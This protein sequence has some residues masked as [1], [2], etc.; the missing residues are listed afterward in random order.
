MLNWMQST[1]GK[2]QGN[3]KIDTEGRKT[4][5]GSPIRQ[6]YF[7]AKWKQLLAFLQHSR[8]MLTVIWA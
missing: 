2:D 4:H 5:S 1:D 7:W 3:R 8:K 6:K